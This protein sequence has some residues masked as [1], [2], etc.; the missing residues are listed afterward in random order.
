M[1]TL[2]GISFPPGIILSWELREPCEALVGTAGLVKAAGV[3]VAAGHDLLQQP[4]G[5]SG[6]QPHKPR[7][8]PAP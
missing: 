4:R 5:V 1:F 7:L 6:L 2:S 3:P 8:S